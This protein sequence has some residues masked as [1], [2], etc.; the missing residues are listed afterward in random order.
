[1]FYHLQNFPT[2]FQSKLPLWGPNT[3]LTQWRCLP[4]M[5]SGKEL[6]KTKLSGKQGEQAFSLE[7][8]KSFFFFFREDIL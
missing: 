2:V 4:F 5:K 7:K 1:M 6:L 8:A 3:D